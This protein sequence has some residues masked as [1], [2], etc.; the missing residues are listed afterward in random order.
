MFGEL[1]RLCERP[2]ADGGHRAAELDKDK[3]AEWC[4]NFLG[5]T[6]AGQIDDQDLFCYFCVWDARFYHSKSIINALNYEESDK[7]DFCWWPEKDADKNAQDL[8]KS[9]AAG[10]VRQCWVSLEKLPSEEN[11]SA[12]AGENAKLRLGKNCCYCGKNNIP[13]WNWAKHMQK[14]HADVA[15]RC[16]YLNNCSK[17]FKTVEERDAHVNEVHLKPKVEILSDCIYCPMKGFKRKRLCKHVKAKHRDVS[18]RCSYQKCAL[19]FKTLAEMD[20][21]FEAKH[22]SREKK[23]NFKCSICDYKAIDRRSIENHEAKNHEVLKTIKCLMCPKI[24]AS[25]IDLRTHLNH[26]HN[27]RKCPACNL[28]IKISNYFTHF[29]KRYC[30]KCKASFDCLE[31]LRKH[32]KNCKPEF[33]C[34]LCLK[35]FINKSQLK[36]HMNRKHFIQN[37]RFSKSIKSLNFRKSNKIKLKCAHCS[38][39]LSEKRFIERH[40]AQVHNLI[41]RKHCCVQ[42]SAKFYVTTELKYHIRKV[43][44]NEKAKCEIC[45]KEIAFKS[46]RNHMIT[47][48]CV[49]M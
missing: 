37:V 38:K 49:N 36:Y 6:L 12:D 1:C 10:N 25:K 28:R 2:A 21:H 42:C 26:T 8:Y 34:E 45:N 27:F 18:I 4:L 33:K 32:E 39:E 20:L 43:H 9:Y 14:N 46:L 16:N 44:L 23:K 7:Q 47:I 40:L 3:L 29:T 35:S 19:Y 24:F 30:R 17:Y 11:A 22:N 13:D 31:L 15:I 48:H 5:T 41:E